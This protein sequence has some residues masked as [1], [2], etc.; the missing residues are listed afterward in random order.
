MISQ[1]APTN[2]FTGTISLQLFHYSRPVGL[3]G[4]RCIMSLNA[5]F[6]QRKPSITEIV[7]KRQFLNA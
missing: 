2:L 6:L 4:S 7:Q 1:I 3:H 5:F